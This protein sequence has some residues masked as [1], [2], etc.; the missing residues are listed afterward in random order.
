MIHFK[1][2]TMGFTLIELMFTLAIAAILLTLAAPSFKD[3]IKNTRLVTEVNNLASGLN[4]TRSEAIKRGLSVTL[5]N[6]DSGGDCSGNWQNGWS[7]FVDHNSNGQVDPNVNPLLDDTILRVG[8]GVPASITLVFPGRIRVT[9]AASGFATNFNSTFKFCDD[10][11]ES[12][13]GDA[14]EKAAKGLVVSP[15]GRVRKAIDADSNGII[16][17]GGGNNVTCP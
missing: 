15:S 8:E 14:R 7:I 13:D 4:F 17:D 2:K 1:A 6:L 11:D 9:Y 10:R 12:S 16:E 3:T 5:C